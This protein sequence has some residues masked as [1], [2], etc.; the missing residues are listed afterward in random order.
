MEQK[1]DD[2]GCHN[3]KQRL[4]DLG[5]VD[6]DIDGCQ[7]TDQWKEK[8]VNTI[9]KYEDIFSRHNLDC[10]EARGYVHH[11]HLVDDRPF[12]LPYRRVPPAH[13]LK[14]RKVLTD[15]EEVGLIRKSVSEYASPLV[16]VWKK[17][18]SLR[19]C[20]DIRWMNA[21]TVKDTHPL[22][23][24]ADC[25]AA[26][27]G[28]AFFS[29]M[30]LTSGFYNIPVH[31]E[32]KKYTAFTTPM[33][34]Y[35]YN[36][37]PQGLC[38]SPASFMRM[39]LRIFGDLNFS[40]LLCYL[41]DLLVFAP[42]EE[43]ALQRLEAVFSR[44]RANNL[45]LAPKKCHFLRKT[46][47][48]LGHFI[49]EDGV[50]VDPEKVEAI[51]KMSHAQLM[52]ADGCT[53]SARRLKSF[54]GMVLYYQHFIPDCSAIARPL[55]ALTGGQKRRGRDG[56][57]GNSGIFRKL[58]LSDWTDECVVAFQ[59]L[60]DALLNCVLLAHPDF[61]RPF[62][63][64]TDASLDGLGAVLCQVPEGE[65]K[66]RPIAF[67]SKTLN[68]N[69]LT[70]IMTKPKLDACEQRWVAKLAQYN[71]DLKRIPGSK[72]TVADAL[73]RDPFAVTVVQRLM[74]ESYL[75][76]LS[77]AVGTLNDDVQDAFH[78]ASYPQEITSLTTAEVKAIC[79]LHIDWECSTEMQAIQLGS[80]TQRL[81][82]PGIDTLPELSHEELRDLQL[83]DCDFH[84]H[85]FRL[86]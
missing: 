3:L 12:R 20:T 48:F 75:A 45:K 37:M 23:H 53:P 69:P 4:S 54:L 58:T 36:R 29:T 35:E 5:L 44:L 21:R 6:I 39:M 51:A 57:K 84:G 31:E 32:D 52:E 27:G 40:N 66:A 10:G 34:L 11:I 70:Y 72:N 71:F 16:M 65:D 14:L 73:S 80:N 30:D 49:K 83:Q 43:Q 8:L 19:L 85:P 86:Q 33:G 81:L 61:E 41:D 64:F 26:L 22:P 24:Q 68:S 56:K 47:K 82:S 55:F 62:I 67:A 13:Y 50:S 59:K 7:V 38:N 60:K 15:M 17:D 63:L 25:L 46:V 77:E 79:Q 76:L 9:T 2:N 74:R 18:G 42:T 1:Q 28:S 78:W